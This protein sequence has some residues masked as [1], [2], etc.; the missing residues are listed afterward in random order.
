MKIDIHVRVKIDHRKKPLTVEESDSKNLFILI[1]KMIQTKNNLNILSRAALVNNKPCYPLTLPGTFSYTGFIGVG[2]FLYLN[3][4]TPRGF[5]TSGR[6]L[7][8]PRIPGGVLR[9]PRSYPF[10][11]G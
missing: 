2:G 3:F 7:H 10:G 5:S 6:K 1:L 9:A 11:K 4:N 8:S